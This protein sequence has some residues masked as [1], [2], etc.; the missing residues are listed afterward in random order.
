MNT[1][2]V[3]LIVLMLAAAACTNKTESVGEKVAAEGP[4]AY[5]TQA[6]I[7]IIAPEPAAAGQMSLYHKVGADS[8]GIVSP[9]PDKG[10]TVALIG[11][12]E[13]DVS[14]MQENC[15]FTVV[16]TLKDP[17]DS[18]TQPVVIN[19]SMT[20]SRSASLPG[21]DLAERRVEV[22]MDAAA[23]NNYSCNVMLRRK[24]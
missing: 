17:Q 15:K 21:S 20:D 1:K 5:L 12:G 8:V 22:Q 4:K 24:G 18:A 11:A 13:H 2:I 16:V 19:L 10:P 9:M 6:D 23:E 7:R 3:A 14:L